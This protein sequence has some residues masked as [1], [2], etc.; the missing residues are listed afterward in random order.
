MPK[1][2]F[3][4][5][6]YIESGFPDPNKN[7]EIES[8]FNWINNLKSK[9]IFEIKKIP[10]SSMRNW[11][12]NLKE[13]KIEHSSGSFFSIEGIRVNKKGIKNKMWDQP[14]IKQAEIGLL[15][16]IVKKINNRIHF[17]VQAKIEPG[18]LNGIQ[19]SPTIQAT[20]SNYTLVHKGVKPPYLKY[21]LSA[22]KDNVIFDQ[23]LSEQG[24]RFLK[25][26]N[27]NIIIYV[28]DEL[29]IYENF[30]WMTLYQL[31]ELLRFDNVV[32]MDTR[33][34]L[35]GIDYTFNSIKEEQTINFP[36]NAFIRSYSLKRRSKES[37]E[38]IINFI[39]TQKKK[40]SLDV[41]KIPLQE[42][43]E[44]LITDKEIFRA[45]SK[46]FKIIGVR[47]NIGNREVKSWDQPMIEP[48]ERLLFGNICKIINGH[49]HFIVQAKSECG[50]VDILE[51]APTVQCSLYDQTSFSSIPF[52]DDVLNPNNGKIIYDSLQSEEGGRFYQEQNRNILVFAEESFCET[53]PDHFIWID[54][55]QLYI[56]NKNFNILNIQL[57]NLLA[58][59]SIHDFN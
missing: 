6:E 44:W 23:L 3:N 13:G 38:S 43:R 37:L 33:T 9:L 25:K 20:K 5:I 54:L 51:L 21:F 17:L 15:G 34:V 41:K 49:L 27:R 30:R 12:I 4:W 31:R 10:I 26:K 7:D 29:D 56:L 11:N 35:S 32:N 57:R 46:Y 48:L 14:I 45:D 8:I 24:S 19:L 18:N 47:A 1:H 2:K 52:L 40:L 58:M 39:D 36:V 50:T 53:L 55:K 28:E 22:K 42:M 59:I 16:F